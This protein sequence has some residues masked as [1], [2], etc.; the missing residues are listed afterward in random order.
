MSSSSRY[1][2]IA[3]PRA[4]SRRRLGEQR[5]ARLLGQP[6]RPRP[7]AVPGDDD[8]AWTGGQHH[9]LGVVRRDA[10]ASTRR[11][12]SPPGRPASRRRRRRTRG[13]GVGTQRFGERHVDVHRP[14]QSGRQA[15][16]GRQRPSTCAASRPLGARPRP[17]AP[18]LGGPADR[19]T[20]QLDLVRGL[21]RPAAA[22]FVRPVGAE[23]SS[24]TPVWLASSTAG[25]RF[26]TAVPD[27]VTS[28]AGTPD[29]LA[30]PSARKPALR[31]S[32]RTCSWIRPAPS[33]SASASARAYAS[34]AERDP[35]QRTACRTSRSAS[36]AT[37]TRASAVEGFTGPSSQPT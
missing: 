17:P 32:T 26:A 19:G 30:R 22:Q 28:T 27:V 18:G 9:R 7:R 2:P 36:A 37:R 1:G 13:P 5:P 29:S 14:G 31:S 24:G 3:W 6:P 12:A 23:H 16:G 34:G 4:G 10:E 21:V 15:P 20:E 8:R 35:G 25:C 33:G 11:P